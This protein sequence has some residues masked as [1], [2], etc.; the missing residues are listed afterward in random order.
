LLRNNRAELFVEEFFN[1]IE[2]KE[3]LM[4]SAPVATH[5]SRDLQLRDIARYANTLARL[6]DAL[7]PPTIEALE[8]EGWCRG[9]GLGSADLRR[10]ADCAERAAR[11][12]GV[13]I[14]S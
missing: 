7:F 11:Q 9:E 2:P 8:A 10:A 4:T 6:I 14:P 12:G 13:F 3:S 1:T 5:V